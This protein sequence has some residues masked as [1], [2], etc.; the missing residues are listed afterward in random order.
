M[1]LLPT[2][3]PGLKEISSGP[4]CQLRMTSTLVMKLL[5]GSRGP[6][7]RP[8]DLIGLDTYQRGMVIM[9][10][11]FLEEL[12]GMWDFLFSGGNTYHVIY[13][14]RKVTLNYRG[15]IILSVYIAT[16]IANFCMELCCSIEHYNV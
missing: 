16:H 7:K 12:R 11:E 14:G 8:G 3:R 6:W 2:E 13:L 10:L 9:S 1:A 15:S 4:R 5:Q